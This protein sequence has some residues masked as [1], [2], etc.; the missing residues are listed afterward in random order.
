[1]FSRGM[2]GGIVTKSFG[3]AHLIPPKMC[4]VPNSSNVFIFILHCQRHTEQMHCDVL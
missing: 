1:M 2:T 4:I 3:V